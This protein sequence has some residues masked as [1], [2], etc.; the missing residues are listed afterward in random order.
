MFLLI[1]EEINMKTLYFD[2]SMGAAGDMLTSALIDLFEDKQ[3]VLDQ[4]NSF[5]IEDVKYELEE[6]EKCGIKGSHIRVYVHGEEE[7]EHHHDHHEHTHHH[8]YHLSDIEHI[9]SELNVSDKVKRD[10]INVYSIIA[11]AESSVH[12]VPVNEIHFHEVGNKDAIADITA[13][14]YLIDKLGVD[15]ILASPVHVGSG[16]VK[17]AHGIL[18]VPAPATALILNDV[19]MYGGRIKGELCT[20]TGAALLKYF[21]KNFGD[22]PVLKTTAIGYGMGN[23]DFEVANCVRAMLAQTDDSVNRIVEF[24]FNVD[25]MTGEQQGYALNKILEAGAVDVYM[26]PIYMKKNRPGTLFTVTCSQ[27]VKKEVLKTIFK[28]TTTIGLKETIK[29]RYILNR[30]TRTISTPLGD[31]RKK[32]VSGYGVNRS[33]YEYDDLSV[34]SEK[35][36]K[37]LEEAEEYVDQ[38]N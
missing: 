36:G 19:P 28:H 24:T 7:H 3:S 27:D 25:D 13:V 16:T 1:I 38:Y 15:T 17:C 2:C 12:G 6:S 33:K 20:P 29:N 9:V 10:V 32:E 5:G 14:C 35:L 23:K 37:S 34:V 8:H 18:P 22:M 31:V 26:T 11:N 30:S 21:V 4:L